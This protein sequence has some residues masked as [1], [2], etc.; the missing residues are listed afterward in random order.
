MNINE[1]FE[2]LQD[3]IFDKIEGEITLHKNT[4]IWTYTIEDIE[5]DLSD[6]EDEED[7]FLGFETTSFEEKLIEI[8]ND[9]LEI[10]QLT[11][12]EYN[13]EDNWRFDE[14]KTKENTITFK[15]F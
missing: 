9:D 6:F 14:Y 4:I 15:I 10:I 12:A 5:E 7:F 2:L 8:Y 13:E 3:N 1:L 11:L